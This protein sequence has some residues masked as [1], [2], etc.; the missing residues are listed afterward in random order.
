MSHDHAHGAADGHVHPAHGHGPQDHASG[1]HDHGPAGHDHAADLRQTPAAR[2]RGALVST[3]LFLV[4]EAVAGVLTHSL[5][6]LADAAH[7]FTDAAALALALVAQHVARR[8]RTARHTY[9]ARRAETLAAFV[10]GVLLGVSSVWIAVEAL[11]R[12]DRPPEVRGGPMMAVAAVGLAVNLFSAW[13]LSRGA[14]GHNANT[15]AALAHVLADAAGSV[16]AIIAAAMIYFFDWNRADAVVSLLLAI[17]ILWGAW[18]L[19]ADTVQVLME[20]APPDI[21]VPAL[22][23]TIESTPGVAGMH[24]LHVWTVAEGFPVVTVHVVL[25]GASHG[26]DVAHAVSRRITSTHGID[27]VTVQVEA[28]SAALVP[29]SQLTRGRG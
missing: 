24:D 5:A 22:Q 14:G 16:G 28:P 3:A 6:L 25:D 2:L 9:G 4:V 15:R 11:G 7:M 10:N 17:A 1:A 13:L 23:A 8:P 18:R 20:G 29:S 21:P 26:T 19:V 27:H 12:W